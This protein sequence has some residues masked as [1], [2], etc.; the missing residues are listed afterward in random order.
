MRRWALAGLVWLSAGASHAQEPEIAAGEPTAIS[1]TIYRDNL[2]LITE[3][4]TVPAI[5]ADARILFPGVMD[6]AIPQSAV[7]RGLTGET[8]RNFR[9]DGLTPRSLLLRSIGEKVRVRR[10]LPGSGEERSEDAII[11]AA[12]D[13]V[14]L[15]FAGH[16]EALGCSGLPETLIFAR[17][18]DRLAAKPTLSTTIT[19]GGAARDITLS[20]L[21]TG[22]DWKAD[23]VVT[24]DDSGTKA[25]VAGWITL[26][27]A[28]EQGFTDARVGVVA[29]DLNRLWNDRTR[30]EMYRA[31]QRACFPLGTTTD[32]PDPIPPPP[33]PP[34]PARRLEYAPIAESMLADEEITVTG[35]RM[36]AAEAKR[37]ELG[38]YQLY[39]LP[40]RTLLS[41]RQTKQVVF[42]QKEDATFQRVHRFRLYGVNDPDSEATPEDTDIVL[43]AKNDKESG[44]GAPLPRGT[45][46]V[47]APGPGGTLYAGE[48]EARDTAVGLEWEIVTGS[49]ASVSVTQK[50][51][52]LKER[53]IRGDRTRVEAEIELTFT[54]AL[55]TPAMLEAIQYRP[56][57][58]TRVFNASLKPGVKYGNPA[59]IVQLAPNS[60]QKVRYRLRYVE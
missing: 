10:T 45:V 41:A 28:G 34:A 35:T 11:A 51:L 15:Q 2:A 8:E 31:A 3:T 17:L 33:P 37:E 29:G 26:T 47:F 16:V 30:Q 6:N 57:E 49:S 18:P 56:G 13:G 23:Y 40:H 12:G 39:S 14:S 24:L 36:K 32:F 60:E 7:I 27:N 19:Q 44:L 9:F 22:L 38:D 53:D 50:T 4:R 54:N 48:G 46:R 59:W 25:S 5:A 58:N 42:I 43:I 21:T 52:S 1:V 20:Y 55:S